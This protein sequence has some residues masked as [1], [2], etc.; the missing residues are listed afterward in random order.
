MGDNTDKDSNSVGTKDV[1]DESQ[2][3]VVV[4]W[5]G[6]LHRGRVVDNKGENYE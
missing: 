1:N 3:W 6:L 4:R 2:G 5:L